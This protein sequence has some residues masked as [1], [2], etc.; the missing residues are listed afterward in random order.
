[1]EIHVMTHDIIDRRYQGKG[2]GT[3]ALK[4]ILSNLEKEGRYNCAEVCVKKDDA[5]ALHIYEKTGFIDTGYIDEDAPDSLNLMFH[6][7][8]PGK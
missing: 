4:L 2:Y 1:M 6:F 3:E 5:A 8:V 7:E